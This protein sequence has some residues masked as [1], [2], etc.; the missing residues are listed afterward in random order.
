MESKTDTLE[1]DRRTMDVLGNISNKKNKFRNGSKVM[2]G[3]NSIWPSSR[4][5]NRPNSNHNDY[6][7][8][9]S[10]T[11]TGFGPSIVACEEGPT[12]G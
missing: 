8:L 12:S 1:D 7:T 5:V 3:E 4:T 9:N 2:M 11:P 6:F 10:I